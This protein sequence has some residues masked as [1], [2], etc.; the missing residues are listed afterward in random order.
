MKLASRYHF[1]MVSRLSYAYNKSRGQ[2]ERESKGV[3][4]STQ[5][6][7]EKGRE[8]Y[9]VEKTGKLRASLKARL[10]VLKGLGTGEGQD[11]L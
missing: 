5:M 3:S 7:R 8:G 2:E 4:V 9:R 10:G 11:Q 1:D 6:I